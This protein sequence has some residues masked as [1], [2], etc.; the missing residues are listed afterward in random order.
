[1]SP[2]DQERRRPEENLGACATLPNFSAKLPLVTP[3][4][5]ASHDHEKDPLVVVHGGVLAVG[6]FL[7]DH[8]G[9][10]QVLRNHAARDATDVFSVFHP[11]IVAGR[12]AKYAVGRIAP[13]ASGKDGKQVSSLPNPTH[14]QDK[15]G[16]GKT[17]TSGSGKKKSQGRGGDNGRDPNPKTFGGSSAAAVEFRRLHEMM[18]AE[19]WYES[20]MR[21]FAI[22][23]IVP[24]LMILV[25]V[26]MVLG[27][28]SNPGLLWICGAASLLGLAWQQLAFL[29]HDTC[30]TGVTHNR[31]L[32]YK[33]AVYVLCP[34]FG[35]SP[36]WWKA[37]HNVHHIVTN[38]VDHDPDIQHLPVFS[39]TPW[40]FEG[41]NSTY[42]HRTLPFDA[43]ARF[44][45]KYQHYLYY[46]IMA[47][48]R[49]N[50]HIQSVLFLIKSKRC[51]HRVAELAALGIYFSWLWALTNAVE[52]SWH[53]LAFFLVSHAVA[54][55]LHV[56]ITLSHFSMALY[57]GV[58]YTG[59]G[60]DFWTTQVA[61]S[62]DVD[63]DWTN[64]WFHG[65]LQH[66]V[67]HHLF[68]RVPRHRLAQLRPLVKG[69]CDRHGLGYRSL[70]FWEANKEVIRTLRNVAEK[71]DEPGASR[72]S[73]LHF[74]VDGLNARG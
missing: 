32:D 7:A 33:F 42:H 72:S 53:R 38:S 3:S 4:D 50:L 10:E 61:T 1:M 39:V 44:L 60:D 13:T 63:T 31:D 16:S 70:S 6:K 68:P 23:F 56:Q 35:I 17:D 64:E 41:V 29:G 43:A 12:L 25:S 36:S 67:S 69:I 11:P 2:R 26:S 9:G 22:K 49:I 71:V 52:G 55:I 19:G 15:S 45:V 51:E 73:Q 66:Q 14:M 27:A 30:H 58:T 5:L 21:F 37:S 34:L 74:I 24:V 62:L 18:V 59:T 46:P 65:G 57:Q 48:A 8:P 40:F 28:G 20:D 47:L 54:G